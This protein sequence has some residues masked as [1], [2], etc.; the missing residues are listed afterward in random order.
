MHMAHMAAY[1]DAAAVH[2]YSVIIGTEGTH[3]F[4]S[5]EWRSDGWLDITTNKKEQI[6][7]N[8]S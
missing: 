3:I 7:L 6:H 5:T 1:G 8:Y 4:F 2:T